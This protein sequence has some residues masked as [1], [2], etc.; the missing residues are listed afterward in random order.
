M[1]HYDYLN[2]H[3][4][5]FYSNFGLEVVGDISAHGDKCYGY[6]EDFEKNGIPFNKGVAIYL[7]TY[8]RPF[9]EEVRNTKNGW[10][11]PID[12]IV[13]NKDKFLHLLPD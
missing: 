9:D 8:K 2:N 3:L 4:K 13:T 6:R 12:W 10:V 1:N 11:N 7:L 5:D